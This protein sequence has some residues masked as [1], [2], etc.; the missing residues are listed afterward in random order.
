M[1]P[2]PPEVTEEL[3][4]RSEV[5]LT[6][7]STAIEGN[8][9]TQS[10]TQIVIEKG[11]TIGGK[12]VLEHLE[13]IGHKEALDFVMELA[14]DQTPL[15]E[16]EIRE[17]H[18]LVM[19][20]Q[21]NSDSGRYRTLD[22]KAAGTD[23][24]YPSH[25]KIAELMAEFVAW[26]GSFTEG[27]GPDLHPVDL[28]T[29]AHLRFVTIH[30]FRDGNGRVGRLLLNLLLLRHGYPIAVLHVAQR[31]AYIGALEAIQSGGTRDALDAL[32]RGAVARSLHETLETALSSDSV[33]VSDKVRAEARAWIRKG[34]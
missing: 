34:L 27:S 16:R 6:H 13:V 30:P 28:A 2:L 11:V 33:V 12:S 20:G 26:L 14:S 4:H 9:L 24:V 15:G 23:Y 1:R 19:K 29:E 32:V 5:A 31:A 18:S 10:E 7:H 8:T 22:V 21:A 3:R 25:L 17:I